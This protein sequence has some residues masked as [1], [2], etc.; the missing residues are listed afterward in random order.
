MATILRFDLKQIRREEDKPVWALAPELALGLF[1]KYAYKQYTDTSVLAEM[2][3]NP[4]PADV[5][6]LPQMDQY[7]S[8]LLHQK[9]KTAHGQGCSINLV[10]HDKDW[11]EVQG[12]LRKV[13]G[14]LSRAVESLERYRNGELD[15]LNVKEFADQLQDT[16]I[17]LSHTF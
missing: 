6:I 8:Q 10:Q 14:P 7:V 15:D 5:M 17:L 9:K 13:S 2:G 11:T 16:A 12:Y 1:N 4:P 3:D